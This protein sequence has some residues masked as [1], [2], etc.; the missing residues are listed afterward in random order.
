MQ[1]QTFQ[2]GCRCLTALALVIL[3]SGLLF[4]GSTPELHAVYPRGI[5]RGN[6]HTLTLNGVRLDDAQEVFFYGE[7]I[8][9]KSVKV[10]DHKKLEVVVSVAPDCRLGEHVLQVRCGKGISD[11][12]SVFVGP[13]PAVVEKEPNNDFA[14]AQKIELNHTIAGQIKGED[15]DYFVAVSYTHLTLPTIYPV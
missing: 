3:T 11:F 9:A 10:V 8:T 6:E 5:Q 12:R 1:N 2:F 13:Y 7:G 15:V 14:T 4:A